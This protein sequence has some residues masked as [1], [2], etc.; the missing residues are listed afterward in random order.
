MTKMSVDR[1]NI[2]YLI[3]V[4]YTNMYISIQNY[5]LATKQWNNI[6]C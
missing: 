5:S 3:Y 2:L 4:D 6:K 1:K